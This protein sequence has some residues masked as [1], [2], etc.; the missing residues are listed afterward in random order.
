MS[1]LRKLLCFIGAHK[2]RVSPTRWEGQE[3]VVRYSCAHCWHSE[4]RRIRT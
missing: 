1:G 2:W 4:E 3:I